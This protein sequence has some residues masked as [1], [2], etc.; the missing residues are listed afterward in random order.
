VV[1]CHA[2]VLLTILW[3]PH[4]RIRGLHTLQESSQ[5]IKWMILLLQLMTVPHA[6]LGADLLHKAEQIFSFRQAR[7]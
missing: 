1:L 3:C 2:E 5:A 4:N 7:T 6:V